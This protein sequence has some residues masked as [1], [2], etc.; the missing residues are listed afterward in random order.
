MG[1][2]YLTAALGVPNESSHDN[3]AAYV[4]NWLHVLKGDA[5][6]V[7][8]ASSAASKA[9]DFVLGFRQGSESEQTEEP[10]AA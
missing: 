3:A 5:R 8:T 10:I 1:A 6:A 9:A 2:A 7:F 4:S